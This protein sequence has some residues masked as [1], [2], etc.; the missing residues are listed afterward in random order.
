MTNL[1]TLPEGADRVSGPGV[2]DLRPSIYHCDPAPGPS[3]SSSLANTI[4][5][6]SLAHARLQ[7]PRL[8]KPEEIAVTEPSRAMEI[9]AAGHATLLGKGE[10]IVRID[11]KDYKTAA[12][13]EA[14]A[15]A[16]AEGKLPI[17]SVDWK[18]V[19]EFVRSVRRQIPGAF[20][21]GTGKPE[22]TLVWQEGK[23]WGRALVDWL[24]RDVCYPLDLKTCGNANPEDLGKHIVERGYD[25]QF[26]WYERGIVKLF[27]EA[28]G[29]VHF[30][31]VFVE[32][33]PPYAV[34]VVELDNAFKAQAREKV[35][36]AL[37]AWQRAIETDEW[38]AYPPQ[39]H[40]L[41]MPIWA[42]A[43]WQN[44]GIGTQVI[45]PRPLAEHLIAM[46]ARGNRRP[47]LTSLAG[48]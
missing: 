1:L 19:S 26:A 47:E 38:P 3:L 13:K 29:R 16:I 30:R 48:G 23:T 4:L 6:S 42:E 14:R 36:V 18:K 12:A 22:V 32:R 44:R 21:P 35:A 46:G 37:A 2:Y 24:S 15:Q 5:D 20:E 11:A 41:S 17:L 34:S 9:G 31:F 45:D 10:E 27:P 28:E 43:R 39:I 7:H 33:E 40:T 8:T 25:V